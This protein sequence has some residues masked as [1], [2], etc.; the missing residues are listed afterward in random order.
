MICD[1]CSKPC[2]AKTCGVLGIVINGKRDSAVRLCSGC[3]AIFHSVFRGDK[4]KKPHMWQRES[5]ITNTGLTG[6]RFNADPRYHRSPYFA[7]YSGF[8]RRFGRT[9]ATL[10]EA[11]KALTLF[12][13]SAFGGYPGDITVARE[14]GWLN[15]R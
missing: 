8:G 10:E 15:G 5:S 2:N 11:D 4:N 12:R 14:R 7:K 6:I 3:L 1:R 9:F 13:I